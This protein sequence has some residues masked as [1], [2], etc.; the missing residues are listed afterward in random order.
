MYLKIYDV[1]YYVLQQPYDALLVNKFF[2]V[3]YEE[4]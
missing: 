2:L 4:Q 1:W 3:R